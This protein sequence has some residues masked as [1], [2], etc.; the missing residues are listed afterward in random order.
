MRLRETAGRATT[1]R[2]GVTAGIAAAWLTDLL[3]ESDGAALTV[4]DGAIFVDISPFGTVTA[5]LRVRGGST[6]TVATGSTACETPEPVQPVYARYWLHSK[7]P[8]PAGNLPLALHLSP[9]RVALP[10]DI[11]GAVVRLTVASGPAGASGEASLI[12]PPELAA[13]VAGGPLRYEL[14][15]GAH[16]AWDVSVRAKAGTARGRYFLAARTTDA[17]GLLIEDA[18]M[19]AVGEKQWPDRGLP[20]EEAMERMLADYGAAAAEV[21]LSLDTPE[22]RLAPGEDG[23]LVVSV[24]SH[25]AS[26]L[27]GEAQLVSPFGTWELTDSS[28]Q[29][30]TLA[31]GERVELRYPLRAPAT[32]RPGATWWALV[33]LMYFGRVWYTDSVPVTIR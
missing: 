19:V 18:A 8:A 9:I 28:L 3:E 32:A 14:A 5:A 26:E 22:V 31:P 27:R 21:E 24:T 25:L 6:G 13:S 10:E 2:L 15:G 23:E 16:A 33:K 30:V 4:A 20:P 1:A 29:P 11:D 12:V 17:T 7:G